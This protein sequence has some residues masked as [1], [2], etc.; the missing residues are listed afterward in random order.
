VREVVAKLRVLIVEDS[1]HSR[2]VLVTLFEK[3]GW[4]TAEAGSLAEGSGL[5]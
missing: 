3:N 1:E 5:A 2:K 4:E